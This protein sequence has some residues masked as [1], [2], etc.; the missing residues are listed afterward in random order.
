MILRESFI[1]DYRNKAVLNK[2]KKM[3]VNIVYVSKRFNYCV[4]YLDNNKGS[5]YLL[6]NLR[7]IRGFVR[8]HPTLFNHEEANI[9]AVK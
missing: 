1:I 8:F 2:L 6:Q 9:E 7:K 3:D 4:V 5:N